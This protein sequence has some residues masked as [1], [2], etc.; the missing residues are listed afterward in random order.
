MLRKQALTVAI[1]ICVLCATAQKK[2]KT[3]VTYLDSITPVGIVKNISDSALLDIVQRQTFRFFWHYAHPV[4]GLARERDNTV[5]GDFYWDFIN[6]AYDEPN[7]SQGTYGSEACAIGGTGFGILSTIVAVNRGWIGRDT[8]LKRLVK[9]ADFLNKA[10]SY[11]GIFPHFMNGTTGKTIP[12]GKL[13]DGADIV[14]TSYL[15]M[16]F[17]CAKEYFNGDT[18]LE[19]YFGNRVTQLWNVANWN[20]HAKG[21]NSLFYW[22]WSPWN[23]FDM[24]FP[25][26]GWNECLITYIMSAS[27]PTHAIAPEV[28]FN[29][30]VNTTS[31]INDKTYFDIKLPLG[32]EYGGP[33]FFAH[34][35]FMGIDPKGLKDWHTDYFEQN[36]NH[37]LINRAWCIN[38]P[39]K[40]KGYGE[41]CWGLTAGDSYKGYVAHCPQEDLGVIQPTA[42]LSSF[43]YTP[44]YSMQVLKHLY[45]DLGDKVWSDYGFVDG[46]SE[47]KDWYA[48]THL[49]IDQGPI[50]VMIENYRSGL[51]WKLFMNIPDVQK[52]LKS[53]G[54]TS[55]WIK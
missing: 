55:P 19:K 18:P 54:F 26:R 13:D 50:V 36:K 38:N 7:F 46:F 37:T 10:E 24:N 28:Y 1:C 23:D 30:F 44:E 45:Y 21:G 14:E 4:S 9:M 15:L 39:K 8:A 20:W 12:F 29:S 5:R 11:H 16:G 25:I 34:Y 27:S 42:A 53:L 3:A 32:F 47:S 40:Y 48:K 6:E 22:H 43:P 2:N 49:A 51:I 33:L 41:N 35:T 52:G 31:Y 17:L